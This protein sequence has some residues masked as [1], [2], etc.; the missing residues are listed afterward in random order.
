MRLKPG[1]MIPAATRGGAKASTLSITP[2]RRVLITRRRR[3]GRPLPPSTEPQ[4]LG[5]LACDVIELALGK[6]AKE[7]PDVTAG[8]VGERECDVESE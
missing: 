2:H 6:R 7:L 1:A 8:F 5:D 4:M 3:S